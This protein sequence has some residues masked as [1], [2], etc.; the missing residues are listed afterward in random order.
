M[1]W[2]EGYIQVL[3]NE[4]RGNAA[5][6]R[7]LMNKRIFG[8]VM[9]AVLVVI[10][11]LLLQNEKV[12]EAADNLVLLEKNH[13]GYWEWLNSNAI[14][15]DTDEDGKVD[16]KVFPVSKAFIDD[17][18]YEDYEY[19]AKDVAR[20]SCRRMIDFGDGTGIDV[21]GRLYGEYDQVSAAV[22]T[23]IEPVV[24][25]GMYLSLE[26]SSGTNEQGINGISFE[27]VPFN[28]ITNVY[29]Y[30][31]Q[32]KGVSFIISARDEAAY[33]WND[34]LQ[35]ALEHSGLKGG[36]GYRDSYIAVVNKGQVEYECSGD[37]AIEYSGLVD[38]M[39]LYVRS[40]G[41]NTGPDSVILLNGVDH[42]LKGRG[43][44]IV[45]LKDGEIID[46][47]SFDTCQY[48]SCMRQ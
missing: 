20:D 26:D 12:V 21:N 7:K 28:Q 16:V 35:Y 34:N 11:I 27:P 2:F 22:I 44:N 42:S 13:P 9:S 25:T 43:L 5:T 45:V 32:L 38:G 36:F 33:S 17:V 40:S 10:T 6:I 8:V 18:S 37:R 1:G 30:L 39:P 24:D 29:T 47:V 31:Y 46:S 23:P 15:K 41:Y 14:W 48:L 4:Q 3:K 19:F